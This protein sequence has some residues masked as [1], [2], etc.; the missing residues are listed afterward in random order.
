MNSKET[1]R[2]DL[3]CLLLVIATGIVRLERHRFESVSSNSIIFVMLTT[4]IFVW[5]RQNRKRLLQPEQRKYVMWMAMLILFLMA[6]RTAKFIF[7]LEGNIFGKYAWY[8][9]YFPQ[10]FIALFI[11]FAVLPIGKNIDDKINRGWKILYLPATLI[12]VGILTND[13]HQQAFKFPQGAEMWNNVPYSYGPLYYIAI[14]W[15]AVIFIMTLAVVFSRCVVL[16]NRR[17]I[18]ISLIPLVMGIIYILL[19]FFNPNSII[20]TMFKAAEVICFV[21]MAFME[22]MVLTGLFPSNDM[23]GEIWRV[24]SIKAGIMDNDGK[25]IYKTKEAG[26]VSKNEIIKA[27]NSPL[28][29][30]NGDMILNSCPVTGGMSY[31]T[32]DISDLNSLRRKLEEMGDVLKEENAMLKAENDIKE[33]KAKL[34]HQNQIY[35]KIASGVKP[36][37]IH[38]QQLL[39]EINENKNLFEENMKYACVL[40]AYVKRYSNLL[41]LLEE[42]GNISSEELKF[43]ISESLEYI[44]FFGVKTYANYH[45]KTRMTGENILMVYKIFEETIEKALPKADAIIVNIEH[46]ETTTLNIEINSP[47]EK[48]QQEYESREIE[49]L[50]G[51]LD[52]KVEEQ[53]EYVTLILP[54]RVV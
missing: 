19:N 8:L 50:D 18:W 2:R 24:S 13:L 42:H 45:G 54:E 7:F 5:I 37:L 10:T 21:F 53:T 20:L 29:L 49:K 22:M 48:L 46:N 15:L 33:K 38:I 30:D 52:I 35:A 41:L 27:K 1:I 25:I 40:N 6:V 16:E 36:Q 44:K 47:R 39:D 26:K 43:A 4:A 34:Q 31:W 17:R 11:F 51:K 28:F 32:F 9:Y 12:V 14:L 3:I 23:Y